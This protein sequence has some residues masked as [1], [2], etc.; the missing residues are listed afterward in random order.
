QE[1]HHLLGGHAVADAPGVL[2]EPAPQR[3]EDAI[4]EEMNVAVDDHSSESS[5]TRQAQPSGPSTFW[6]RTL[7][8]PSPNLAPKVSTS[9]LQRLSRPSASLNQTGCDSGT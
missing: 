6:R 8:S 5:T 2:V 4:G 1:P 3:G 7:G 9:P